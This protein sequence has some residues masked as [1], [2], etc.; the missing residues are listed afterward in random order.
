MNMEPQKICLVGLGY[1]GLPLAVAL[2]KHF[3]VVGFDVNEKRI[4]ELQQGI[5][6]SNEVSN[7]ELN[8]SSIHFTTNPTE[9]NNCNF[10]IVCVPTPIDL[11]KKPDLS[12]LELS[13]ELIGKNLSEGSIVVYESTV[14]PG[15]TEDVCVP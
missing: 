15:V 3:S 12:Y 7:E 13:S 6:D 8:H 2:N 10:I 1:V 4:N 9:M 11:H 5:D 14:Y